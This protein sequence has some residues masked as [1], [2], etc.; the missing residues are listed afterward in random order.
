MPFSQDQIFETGEGDQWFARNKQGLEQFD[1]ETDFPLRLMSLYD[2]HPTSVLEIGAASGVRGAAIAKRC[3][4]R[5]V[6]L[7][8]SADAVRYGKSRFPKVEFVRGAASAIPLKDSFDLIVVN[9]VFHWIDRANLLRSVAEVDRVLADG[10]FLII[11][12]FCPSGLAKV[13]YHH[14]P[15]QKIYT[16]KQNYAATFLASGLYHS[17]SLLTGDHSSSSMSGISAEGERIGTWLLRKVLE[18]HYAQQTFTPETRTGS[19]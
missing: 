7:E 8:P 14:L 10:G 3:K 15:E 4:S 18:E 12:D 13:Q 16:Y 11:G 9:F 17:V 1:P 2:L 19:K 5:V 6:A